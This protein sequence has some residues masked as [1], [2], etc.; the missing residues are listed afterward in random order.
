MIYWQF[1]CLILLGIILYFFKNYK[2]ALILCIGYSI[3]SLIYL[4]SVLFT[5]TIQFDNNIFIYEKIFL[6]FRIVKKEINIDK[7]KYLKHI[8]I[9][10]SEELPGYQWEL[11]Y[12][13]NVNNSMKLKIDDMVAEINNAE[14]TKIDDGE[15]QNLDIIFQ[16]IAEKANVAIIE[17]RKFGI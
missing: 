2:E 17:E 5:Q 12:V 11:G 16:K 8:K 6:N 14:I 1:G 9:E 10:Y 7:I 3:V 15:L 13:N 4:S